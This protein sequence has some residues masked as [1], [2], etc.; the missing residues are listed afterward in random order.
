M[1]IAPLYRLTFTYSHS[2]RVTIEGELGKERS[3]FLLAE[4]SCAGRISG[5]FRGANFPRR[6][7]DKQFIPD[8]KGVIETT[9]GA[10]ILCEYRGFGRPDPAGR[11]Q[12]VLSATHTSDDERYRWLNDVVCVG[13]GEV[14]V[15]SGQSERRGST[16]IVIDFSELVWEP[17]AE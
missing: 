3:M 13:A 7:V 9:D 10:A 1:R 14:R 4:G 15:E 8:F 2:W 6:R 11:R 16:T 12:I 17:L 5:S